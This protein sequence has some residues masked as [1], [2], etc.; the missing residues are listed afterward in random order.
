MYSTSYIISVYGQMES[1]SASTRGTKLEQLVP[2]QYLV[3]D[4]QTDIIGP[5][6]SDRF[7]ISETNVITKAGWMRA[8]YWHRRSLL[9]LEEDDL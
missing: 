9:I 8:F 2:H 6:L 5:K 3:K 4:D 7:T 1:A